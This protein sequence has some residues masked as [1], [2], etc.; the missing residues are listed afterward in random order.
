MRGLEELRTVPPKQ[1]GPANA[2]A[3]R[4]VQLATRAARANIAEAPDDSHS[5]LAWEPASRSFS[6]QPIVSPTGTIKV[7]VSLAPFELSIDR[8]H[9]SD[10]RLPLDQVSEADAL[11][12]LDKGL[13]AS[14]LSPAGGI[15][16]PYDLPAAAAA[17]ST[18]SEAGHETGLKTLAAWYDLAHQLLTRFADREKAIVPGPSPVRCWPHHFDIATYVSLE[19]GDPEHA[20][21]V[22]IGMSPGDESYD[23]PYF[24]INPWP[25]PDPKTLPLPPS[26]GHW[27]TQGFTGAIATATECLSQCQSEGDIFTFIEEAF[28][29]ARQLSTK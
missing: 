21:G 5:S 14:G 20:R 1:L 13:A 29:I 2:M 26:P 16:S 22:G 7:M 12:W 28:A 15:K 25:Y 11:V 4:A 23:E 19:A 17:I 10:D 18:Y 8:D 27:H 3:H 6:S 9:Q 24:Y